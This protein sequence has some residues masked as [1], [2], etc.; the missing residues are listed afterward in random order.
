MLSDTVTTEAVTLVA[1]YGLM[2][3]V[4]LVWLIYLIFKRKQWFLQLIDLTSFLLGGV[5]LILLFAAGASIFLDAYPRELDAAGLTNEREPHRVVYYQVW[6]QYHANCSKDST[7]VD[8]SSMRHFLDEALQ[9]FEADWYF[10][11]YRD[12]PAAGTSPDIVAKIRE[13]QVQLDRVPPMSE[14]MDR[15]FEDL[16]VV[17]WLILTFAWVLGLH[18]R[19]LLFWQAYKPKA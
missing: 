5:S 3:S 19:W 15:L 4:L 2:G 14:R 1:V 6:D 18:R 11:D 9:T 13:Y 7:T 12:T 16:N 17:P 8:C 10:I